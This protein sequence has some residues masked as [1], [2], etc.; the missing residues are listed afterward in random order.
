MRDREE[1][2]EELELYKERLE[3]A[4]STGN[5]AWWEMELPSGEVRFN[6]RK[7]EMLGYDPERFQTYE[8]FTELVHPEDYG[9]AMEAMRDHLEG[10]AERYEV[11]YRIENSDGDYIWFRDVGGITEQ[12][13][14]YKKV[15]GIVINITERK[16]VEER[17]EFLNSLL[18]H[19]IKNKAQAVQGYL[20]LLEEGE[21]ELS[22]D[23]QDM[24][25]G[26]LT[27][28]KESVNLIQ[29]V[30]LL[31]DAQEEEIKPVDIASTI[32][33]TVESNEAM[34]ERMGIELSLEC[35]SVKCKVEGGSLLQEVFNN[36]I[37]NSIKH[38]EG[39]RIKI[40]GEVKDDEVLCIIEDDGKGIPDDKKDI[41][42]EKGYTTDRD[43]G[44]GLGLFLVKNLLESYGGEIEMKDSDMDGARFDVHLKRYQTD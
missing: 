2:K 21:E 25:K 24:V 11:E 13:D 17:E 16:K 28:N 14:E 37:E 38:S 15:A 5:L 23:S 19:D 3:E 27:A 39:T 43:R 35:P 18:R 32:K 4:M 42:F 36:I 33:D 7:A 41:V 44:T 20:Q 1:L 8:D 10:R 6:D 26:A 22:K 31:L 34:A 12:E 29:K 30:R 9:R 40:A